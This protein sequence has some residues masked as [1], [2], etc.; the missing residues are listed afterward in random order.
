MRLLDRYLLRELLLP[1]S[2]CLG[3][4]LISFIAFDLFSSI[5]DFQ[6]AK[7]TA[8][9]ILQYY[10]CR[11]P[12]FLVSMYL[13]PLSLLLAL[14]YALANHSRHNELTAMRVAGMSLWRIAA[15]YFAV[16]M[17]LCA[18]VYFLNEQLVPKGIE[19]SERIRQGRLDQSKTA[20]KAWQ[21]NVFFKYEI[22]DRS[23]RIGVYHLISN[24]MEQPHIDWKRADGTR[25]ELDAES[26]RW[27]DRRWVFTKADLR[28]YGSKPGVLP[29]I[30]YTNQL[31][32]PEITETPRMIRS[33]I[34]LSPVGDRS[35][36]VRRVQLSS[37]SLIEF[38]KLHP[39]LDRKRGNVVRTTLHSR[40]A[41]PWVCVVVVLI[42]V[43]FGALPGRR[44]VF[45]GVA[46]SVFICFLFLATR[47]LTLTLGTSGSLPP[48]L[49]AW[50][51]NCFFAIAGLGLMWRVR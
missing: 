26:A 8:G 21:P 10:L 23:W 25:L 19:A 5:A 14:L 9:E 30:I 47:E 37:A 33:E 2:Y 24:A 38:L 18:L 15:P 40:F 46:S 12:D 16:G 45:V 20:G 41:L 4:F 43:P 28:T 36:S 35:L 7:L 51:P 31:V 48:W 13:V 34:K 42:A 11:A 49:A 3:G 22:A 1:L 17:A 44:N 29:E 39:K 32:I 27:V 6:K 50:L